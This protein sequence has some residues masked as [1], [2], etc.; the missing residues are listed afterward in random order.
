MKEKLIKIF[1]AYYLFCGF[2]GLLIPSSWYWAG[3]LAPE[4]PGLLVRITAV[5]LLALGFGFMSARRNES[6]LPGVV[7]VAIWSSILDILAVGL[8]IWSAE[9]ST[10]K[11]GGFIAVDFAAIFGLAKFFKNG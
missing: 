7:F 10:L 5:L 1:A 2:S 11:G 3:G 9:I 8:G 4:L 6:L